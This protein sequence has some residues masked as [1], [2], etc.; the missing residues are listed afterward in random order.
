V[1]FFY[2]GAWRRGHRSKY[3]AVGRALAR[4]GIVTVIPD[5][6]LYPRT[7]FPGFVHDGA[8]ALAWTV[9]RIAA[10]GGDPERIVLM[11]HSAGAHLAA[12]LALDG[13]YLETAGSSADVIRGVV[14]LAGPYDFQPIRDPA[15]REVFGSAADQ[16]CSQ[17]I[18]FA[19]QDA[20]PFLLLTGGRDRTVGPG[21]SKR[22]WRRLNAA[23]GRAGL[24]FYQ[25][26]GHVGV[27]LALTPMLRWLGPVHED[28]LRF[29]DAETVSGLAPDFH[30]AP[31]EKQGRRP[32]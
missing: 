14:G 18:H 26:L 13:R 31:V 15:V 9:E 21:N 7:R 22:L 25:R 3:R 28:V 29:V 23:G 5:Y 4:R 17:P 6:R 11:G 19:R 20:P 12:L 27:L 1:V 10:Y 24:V 8:E 30:V 32:G 16:P 2:G